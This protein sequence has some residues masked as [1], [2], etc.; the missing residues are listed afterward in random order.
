MYTAKTEGNCDTRQGLL[1]IFQHNS[2]ALPKNIAINLTF[3]PQTREYTRTQR[4][5]NK[6]WLIAENFWTFL[7]WWVCKCV[8]K[9]NFEYC[10]LSFGSSRKM[11][12]T[13]GLQVHYIL[14]I[15]IPILMCIEIFQSE[16]FKPYNARSS[17]HIILK[18]WIWAH[19]SVIG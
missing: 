3:L 8:I 1:S 15:F 5:H 19:C 6:V 16:E 7:K 2:I 9:C 11:L 17:L 4:I 14:T 12:D 13:P 18:G 10:H